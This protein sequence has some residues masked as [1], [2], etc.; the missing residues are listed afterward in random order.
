MRTSELIGVPVIDVD[1]RMRGRVVDIRTYVDADSTLVVDGFIVGEHGWRLFGYERH[2]EERPLLI[3]WLVRH[4][5]GD[6]RF[7]HWDD[8]AVETGA[9]RLR[10]RGWDRLP[11]LSEL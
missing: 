3:H 11:H 7:A 9:L 8:V 2:D 1:G 4:L 10:D 5:L 6:S